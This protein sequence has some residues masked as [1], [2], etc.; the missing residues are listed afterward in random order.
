MEISTEKNLFSETKLDVIAMIV[1]K[2]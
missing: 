1:E 2:E